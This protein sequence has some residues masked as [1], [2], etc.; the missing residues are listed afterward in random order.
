MQT[1]STLRQW[2]IN[3]IKSAIP[4]LRYV[5]SNISQEEATTYRDGGTGWTVVEV[6]GHLSDFEGVFL[7]RAEMTLIHDNPPLPFPDPDELATISQYNTLQLTEV[8]DE[9]EETRQHYIKF[10]ESIESDDRWER[11]GAHPKRGP[12]SLN[13]QLFLTPLHDLLHTEQIVKIMENKQI[14]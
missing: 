4:M 11:V 10:W 9:W 12:F 6:M 8:Y 13:D 3:Q 7:S 1:M 5:L 14:G 2:Q